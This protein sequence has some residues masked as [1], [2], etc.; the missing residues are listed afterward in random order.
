MSAGAEEESDGTLGFCDV[1]RSVTLLN[2]MVV[3]ALVSQGIPA[4][5]MHPFPAWECSSGQLFDKDGMKN[6]G[7]AMEAGFVP[8]LHGDAVLDTNLGCTILG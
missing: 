7:R 1:R 2:H 3:T 6:V 8:V 4:V 5:A